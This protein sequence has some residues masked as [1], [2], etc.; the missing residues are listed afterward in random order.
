VHVPATIATLVL[1]IAAI[2]LL[3]LRWTRL[4]GWT[5]L[6]LLC[7]SV[8]FVLVMAFAR[9]ARISTTSDQANAT[10]YWASVLGYI[11]LLVV[12]TLLKPHWLTSLIAVV[13]ML[14]LLSASAILPLAGI[15]SSLPHRVQPLGNGFVGDLVPVDAVTRGASG[16]DL[17]IYR[18]ISWIPL[19]QRRYISVRYFN[20][21][22]DTSAAYAVLQPD[23]RS[24]LMVCPTTEGFP[25][26]DGRSIVLPLYSGK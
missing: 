22:C 18:R 21:Q 24:V 23:H 17:T 6:L 9:M 20:T 13:L 19:L 11:F 1:C 10:F 25:A 16:T 26:E 8:V 12:F 15:F 3:R 14:P 4:S 5:K 7:L 2:V